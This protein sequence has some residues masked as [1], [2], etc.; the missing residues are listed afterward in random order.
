MLHWLNRY[1]TTSS[2]RVWNTRVHRSMKMLAANSAG[3]CRTGSTISLLLPS[4]FPVKRAGELYPY[5]GEF[6]VELH[7][8]LLL[9]LLLNPPFRVLKW[10]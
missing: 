9:M 4:L 1:I 3:L 7:P 10:K 8:Y 2:L 5:R 6:R